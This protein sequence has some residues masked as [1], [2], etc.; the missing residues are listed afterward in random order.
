MRILGTRGHMGGHGVLWGCGGH[1][2]MEGHMGDTW[3]HG[4]IGDMG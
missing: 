4:D 3:G 2:D 1:G